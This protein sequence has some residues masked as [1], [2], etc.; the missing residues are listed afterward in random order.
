MHHLIGIKLFASLQAFSPAEAS[1]F[2]ISAGHTVEDVL[3][4]LQ[5]PLE[6]VKLIFVNGVKADLDTVLKNGDRVGVFPAV[7]GG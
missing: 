4:A 1:S 2:P 3:E 5:V 6:A 7:G